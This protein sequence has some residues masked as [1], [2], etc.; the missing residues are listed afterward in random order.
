MALLF[1]NNIQIA[2][3]ADPIGVEA[4]FCKMCRDKQCMVIGVVYR[5]PG[6]KIDA[7]Q[8]LKEYI[9]LQI[10]K[11]TKLVLCGDFNLP[12]IEW[13]TFSS[14][15]NDTFNNEELIDIAF[16]FDLVQLVHEYTRIHGESKSILDLVFVRSNIDGHYE[17]EVL[18][19]LSDHK[20][21]LT[22]LRF[23]LPKQG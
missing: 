21:V 3:M 19:G 15:T 4:L 14:G 5:P 13:P 9:G 2:R 17:C 22:Q 1:K 6:T 16:R 23:S 7:L 12:G 11:D 10:T 18:D 20:C 8:N